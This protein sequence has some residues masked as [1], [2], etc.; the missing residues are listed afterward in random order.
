MTA[1]KPLYYQSSDNTVRTADG[2]TETLDPASAGLAGA[3]VGTTDTQT[4]SNK[5]LTIPK[6]SNSGGLAEFLHADTGLTACKFQST[7]SAVNYLVL[8]NQVTTGAPSVLASGS[9]VTISINVTPKG[10]YAA[11]ARAQV[12]Y[13]SVAHPLATASSLAQTLTGKTLV[14]PIIGA[15]DWAA[16]N[17][18]HQGPG[19]ASGGILQSSAIDPNGSPFSAALIGQIAGTDYTHVAASHYWVPGLLTIGAPSTVGLVTYVNTLLA[20]PFRAPRRTTFSIGSVSVYCSTA[21]TAGTTTGRVG[22]YTNASGSQIFPNTLV[23]NSDQGTF[24]L[25]TTGLK[26]ITFGT[27]LTQSDLTPGGLFWLAFNHGGTTGP[28]LNSMPVTSMESVIGMTSAT[29]A[30]F[31]AG[32][33]VASAYGSM[34]ASFPGGGVYISA[35]TLAAYPLVGMT[36]TV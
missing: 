27:A 3:F 24:D 32:Y 20:F 35:A 4:L 18:T 36:Y 9:D 16:A 7:V 12:V 14:A 15:A 21:I 6:L 34:P 23:P 28:S 13:D 31:L 26:T 5:T 33:S 10:S 19:L 17:H 25:S 2:T 8:R 11:G 22:I 30:T 29:F 1:R